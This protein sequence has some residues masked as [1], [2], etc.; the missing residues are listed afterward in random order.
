MITWVHDLPIGWLIVVVFVGMTVITAIVF[1]GVMAVGTGPRGPRLTISTGMLPPMALVFGLLVGFL[2]AQLWG[3]IS[4]ARDAVNQE[5]SALRTVELLAKPFPPKQRAR[6]DNL[7][8]AHILNAANVEWPDMAK[9]HATLTVV[10]RPLAGA[11]DAA[12]A[13]KPTSYGQRVAQREMVSGLE[14][15]MTSRRARIILS[16]S[17]VNWIRWTA[18]IALAVFT[19]IGIALVHTDNRRQAAVAMSIFA[20]ATAITIVVI[21]SED[22][23]F[24]GPFRVTP[25]VLLQVLPPR[26]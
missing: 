5:A 25:T 1:A 21:A 22:R 20:A 16:Q 11:L 3:N 6:I 18:V 2:V 9:Q 14:T 17:T 7:V 12:V 26:S 13:L 8:R 4:D 23:P 15:V 24:S 10:S 19:L